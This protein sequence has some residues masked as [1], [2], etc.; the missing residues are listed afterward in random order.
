MGCG[1]SQVA[2]SAQVASSAT[3]VATLHEACQRGDAAKAAQLIKEGANLEAKD[4][5][6]PRLSA[7]PAVAP[8]KDKH[9]G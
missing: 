9:E 6:R 8:R 1:A 5:V 7:L 3:Q 2:P 4:S